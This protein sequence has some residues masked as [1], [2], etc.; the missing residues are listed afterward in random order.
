MTTRQLYKHIETI[1]NNFDF[2]S[3]LLIDNLI[4]IG[5]DNYYQLYLNISDTHKLQL[6]ISKQ[7]SIIKNTYYIF[8]Y[9]IIDGEETQSLHDIKDTIPQK[10]L[11]LLLPTIRQFNINLL[12]NEEDNTPIIFEHSI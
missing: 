1:Y 4:I 10:V 5:N 6:K 11:E 8:H 9:E 7:Y 3:K 2:K 12:L